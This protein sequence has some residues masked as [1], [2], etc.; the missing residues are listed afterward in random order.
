MKAHRGQPLYLAFI[1]HRLSGLGLAIFLPFHLYVLGLALGDGARL[2]AVGFSSLGL[3][4][5]LP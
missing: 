4:D 1:L 2:D 5:L 3:F